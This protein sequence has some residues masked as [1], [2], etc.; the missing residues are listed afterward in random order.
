ME[1]IINGTLA[2]LIAGM[3]TLLGSIPVFFLKTKL[4]H[5]SYSAMLGIS[6]GIMLAATFFSLIIPS[7]E[8]SD[9]YITSIGILTGALFIDIIAK[10]VPM[11]IF[12]KG[13]KV[14]ILT[15]KEYFFLCLL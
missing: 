2:S 3:A 10:L 15:C 13:R 1:N 12:L 9:V 11:S 7:I 6:G 14:R 8:M 5:K 4:S